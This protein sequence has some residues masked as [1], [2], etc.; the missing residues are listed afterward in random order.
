MIFGGEMYVSLHLPFVF[1]ELL[2]TCTHRCGWENALSSQH[3]TDRFR[4]YRKN[5]HAVMGSKSAV[6]RF[7]PLQDVEVRRFLLR[8]LEEPE[9]LLHHIRTWVCYFCFY[10]PHNTHETYPNVVRLALSS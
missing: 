2:T 6:S 3:Y 1:I 7:Y 9:N 4:A 8:V 10:F 5:I